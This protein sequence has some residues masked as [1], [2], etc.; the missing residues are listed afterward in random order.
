[1]IIAEVNNA[2]ERDSDD[3]GRPNMEGR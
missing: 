2:S 1:M 3:S